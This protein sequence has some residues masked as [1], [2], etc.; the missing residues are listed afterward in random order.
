MPNY[1]AIA[2]CRVMPEIY[3]GADEATFGPIGKALVCSDRNYIDNILQKVDKKFKAYV[4]NVNEG[5]ERLF[6]VSGGNASCLSAGFIHG[7]TDQGCPRKVILRNYKIEEPINSRSRV[8]FSLGKAL[9]SVFA[10]ENPTCEMGVR[11]SP[12]PYV[13]R[14]TILGLEADSYNRS[15][16]ILYELKSVSSTSVL[17]DV[18]VNGAWKEA[19]A[20][21]LALYMLVMN[22]DEMPIDHGI[23]RYLSVIYDKQT[24]A[25]VPHKFA[26]GD[27]KE[28]KFEWVHNKTDSNIHVD[29]V[30]T[31]ITAMGSQRHIEYCA[32]ALEEQPKPCELMRPLDSEG[33]N[34]ACMYCKSRANCDLA[35]S[36]RL[37]MK[38]FIEL[39]RDS[40]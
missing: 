10:E 14:S 31:N 18:L 22:S 29:G 25:K 15:K 19:N 27:S 34:I 20:H 12:M 2:S 3:L 9:E 1:F 23:L 17:K 4:V 16:G 28:F 5:G 37:S 30:Q 8:T 6:K 7:K 21:Q 32:W 24:I 36:N 40:V 11:L 33:K 39:C 26:A 38:E 35:D 13:S